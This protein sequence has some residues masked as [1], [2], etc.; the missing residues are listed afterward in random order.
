MAALAL[1]LVAWPAPA[2][3]IYADQADQHDWLQQHV[4]QVRLATF[5]AKPRTRLYVGTAAG[6]LAALSPKD[7]SLLWRRV[8]AEGDEVTALAAEGTRLLTLTDGGKQAMAWDAATGAAV[9]APPALASANLPG[10][11]DAAAIAILGRDKHAVGVVAAAGTAKVRAR[12]SGGGAPPPQLPTRLPTRLLLHTRLLLVLR[13]PYLPIT[14][15]HCSHPLSPCFILLSCPFCVALLPQG[16]TL[17]DG[18]ELWSADLP[19]GKGAAAVRLAAAGGGG[20]WAA[21]LQ[22]GWVPCGGS[23]GVA[24]GSGWA[25]AKATCACRSVSAKRPCCRR[26][27]CCFHGLPS[28]APLPHVIG[29]RLLPPCA[30]PPS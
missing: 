17:E 30:A 20:A 2:A 5:T 15:F 29:P 6:A 14:P 11:A 26:H 25:P 1:L 19:G 12:G 4:G 10:G 24:L 21:T 18:D 7:G 16:Y 9:W 28:P 3:A 8:L 13:C 23:V 27:S 22:P